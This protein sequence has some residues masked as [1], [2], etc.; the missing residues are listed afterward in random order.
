[1]A[2]W[3]VDDVMRSERIREQRYERTLRENSEDLSRRLERLGIVHRTRR[4]PRH[5]TVD[6]LRRLRIIRLHDS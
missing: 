5:P 6:D 3:T 1:M 4:L 2:G